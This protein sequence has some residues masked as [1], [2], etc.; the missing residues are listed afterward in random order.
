MFQKIAKHRAN[1]ASNDV[2]RPPLPP[3]P[4]NVIMFLKVHYNISTGKFDTLATVFESFNTNYEE[5]R[6]VF[7]EVTGVDFI[8]GQRFLSTE[9]AENIDE[10]TPFSEETT[11]V[12]VGWS[13]SL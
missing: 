1:D 7:K 9:T 13:S 4:L 10:N 12:E 8:P 5:L 11:K 2:H 3:A 6:T